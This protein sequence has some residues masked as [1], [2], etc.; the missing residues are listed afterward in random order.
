MERRPGQTMGGPSPEMK[1]KPHAF[2]GAMC[3]DLY[4]ETGLG[5]LWRGEAEGAEGDAGRLLQPP[6]GSLGW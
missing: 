4:V 2:E 5:L 3:S 1:G 6:D